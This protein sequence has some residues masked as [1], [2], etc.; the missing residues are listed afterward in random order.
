M[1]EA[2]AIILIVI[3]IAG[4]IF[5]TKIIMAWE[6]RRDRADDDQL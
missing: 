1:T 4:A 2:L 6:E 5:L 3:I